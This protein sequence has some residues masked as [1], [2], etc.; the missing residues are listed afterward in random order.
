MSVTALQSAHL[1]KSYWWWVRGFV[2]I[3]IGCGTVLW[4]LYI[5]TFSKFS[6]SV[7]LLYI[8][9]PNFSVKHFCRLSYFWLGQ[10]HKNGIYGCFQLHMSDLETGAECSPKKYVSQ[11]LTY[12]FDWHRSFW[13][14]EINFTYWD[15]TSRRPMMLLYGILDI[16]KSHNCAVLNTKN[17]L[18]CSISYLSK[19]YFA[20]VWPRLLSG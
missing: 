14:H 4:I 6:F 12:D 16:V 18:F 5:C 15:G 8:S 3:L 19:P 9:F 7:N 1:R 10:P 17:L 11:M 2:L 20:T 13:F